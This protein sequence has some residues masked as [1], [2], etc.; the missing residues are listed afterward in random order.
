MKSK[1]VQI[2]FYFPK[3]KNLKNKRGLADSILDMMKK[4]KST[5]YAGY[6]NE[7]SLYDGIIQ[8]LGNA[9]IKTYK[10]L[11]ESQ[12]QKIQE[13]INK[14]IIKCNDHLPIPTKNYVF[15]FPYLPTEKER[16]FE[17]I[18]GI[19]CYS[20]VFHLF[21]SPDLWSPKT[22]ASTVAHELN[23]T[24]FFYYHY[25]K[26]N[27]YTLLDRMI[28]EGLAENFR[29]QVIES[30]PSP[31]AIALTYKESTDILNSMTTEDLFSKDQNLIKEILFGSDEYKPWTGYSVGYW[32]IKKLI[33]KNPHMS[34]DEIMKL[35]SKNILDI[36]KK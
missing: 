27:N 15:V 14:T 16:I 7:K 34:W 20:C 2:E 31:W 26:L 3:K 6:I 17:G 11:S 28:I 1:L 36:I 4:N 8:H 23:H 32:L 35:E 33:Q 12:I 9:D 13:Q 21:I 30:T 5:T 18:M 24:I 22:L 19:A 10:Q 29:E 25:E